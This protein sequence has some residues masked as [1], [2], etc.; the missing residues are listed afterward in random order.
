MKKILAATLV[1]AIAACNNT[2]PV[3]HKGKDGY[4][5]GKKQYDKDVVTIRFVTHKSLDELQET[6][7]V[8]K[9]DNYSEVGAFSE[10]TPP[11]NNCIVHILDPAVKYEPELIG[12]EILH[13][14]Y[15][16]WHTNNSSYK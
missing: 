11:F 12:H 15:G 2:Q 4:T 7:R 16:Q 14:K 5:F 3:Q 9:V 10:L 13:C 6:A 1:L 8:L